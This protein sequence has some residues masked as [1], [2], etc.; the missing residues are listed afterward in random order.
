[1]DIIPSYNCNLDCPFCIVHR[2]NNGDLLDLDWLE[3]NIKTVPHNYV[4][5]LG[6]ELSLLPNDYMK[7]LIEIGKAHACDSKVTMY[8]N[9]VKVSPFI[10]SVDVIVSYDPM[11]RQL[12]NKV[13]QNMLLLERPF[14]INM[15]A[16]KHVVSLGVEWLLKL[17]KKIKQLKKISISTLTLFPGCPDLRPDP[18]DLANFCCD[19]IKAKTNKIRFYPVSTWT[20]NYVKQMAPEE[21]IE[22]LPNKKFRISLRDFVGAKE[23]DTYEQCVEYYKKELSSGEPCC[24][25]CPYFGRCT[26]MYTDNRRCHADRM[27][28]EAILSELKKG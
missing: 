28:T 16:T 19:I 22:I 3:E 17:F 23:L 8:T 6:G 2:H 13:L 11:V 12:Q 20:E 14:K 1:M 21:T 5:I 18:M 26:H 9:L 10:D 15:L 7:R 24:Q 25:E 27:I 4:T